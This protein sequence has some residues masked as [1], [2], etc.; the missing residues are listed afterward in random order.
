MGARQ[1]RCI[2]GLSQ[3]NAKTKLGE[4]QGLPERGNT[5]CSLTLIRTPQV[6]AQSRSL[7]LTRYSGRPS[8]SGLSYCKSPTPACSPCLPYLAAFRAPNCRHGEDNSGHMTSS[9][10]SLVVLWPHCLSH[11]TVATQREW[12]PREG[13]S[14]PYS[15]CFPSCFLSFKDPRAIHWPIPANPPGS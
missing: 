13:S 9:C 12:P 8:S 1:N 15:V 4:C 6:G 5:I 14:S 7:V 3:P 11:C 10:W 2:P